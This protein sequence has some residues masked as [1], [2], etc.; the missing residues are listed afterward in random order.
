MTGGKALQHETKHTARTYLV[1]LD[2]DDEPIVRGYFTLTFRE[3]VLADGE[4][5]VGG[6]KVREIHGFSRKPDQVPGYL[7]GQIGK[8]AA[9]PHE[10]IN[11]EFLLQRIYEV[12]KSAHDNIGGRV[13]FLECEDSETLI[14]L[15][16]N[17]DFK[18]LQR[19]EDG[20]VIMYKPF[21]P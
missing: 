20:M 4:V 3:I 11:L 18:Y 6:K 19:R 17:H 1:F 21:P 14:T 10:L 15:Y 8:N 2:S 7:I 13:V 9:Y 12:L 16:Q 5:A